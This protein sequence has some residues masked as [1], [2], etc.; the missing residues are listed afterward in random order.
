M[1]NKMF[2][3]REL[4]P[5]RSIPLFHILKEVVKLLTYMLNIAKNI[6]Y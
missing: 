4:C 2:Y 1:F 6:K 3:E 5:V